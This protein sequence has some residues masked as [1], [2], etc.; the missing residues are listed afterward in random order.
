M[1]VV[2]V[3]VDARVMNRSSSAS[4]SGVQEQEIW[5]VVEEWQD[6]EC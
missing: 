1:V 5:K 2:V 6:L 3:V 4:Q